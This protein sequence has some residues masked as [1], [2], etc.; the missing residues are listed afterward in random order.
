[1][2]TLPRLTRAVSRSYAR[3]VLDAGGAGDQHVGREGD[4]QAVLDDGG[5]LVQERERR[6]QSAIGPKSQS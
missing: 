6:S 4:E 2:E 3:L 1:M 5:A